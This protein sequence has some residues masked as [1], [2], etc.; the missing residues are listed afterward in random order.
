MHSKTAFTRSRDILKTVEDVA[1]KPPV[2]TKTAYYLPAD[3]ENGRFWKRNSNRHI[4]ETASCEHSKM[5]KKNIFQCFWNETDEFLECRY[6]SLASKSCN[7]FLTVKFP[8]VFKLF[9]Y[10]VYA[11]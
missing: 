1:D 2:H 11:S 6:I 10:L 5:I 7:E 9:R 4:L 3:F 8:T